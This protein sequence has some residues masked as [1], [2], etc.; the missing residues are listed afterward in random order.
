MT[1]FRSL[2]EPVIPAPDDLTVPQFIFDV[3]AH[4]TRPARREE[5]PCF[6]EEESGRPVYISE[7][8]SR[9]NALAKGIRACWGIG[10]GDVVALFAPNHVDYTVIAWAVHRLGVL[11]QQ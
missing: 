2:I 1:L 11:L 4:P 9:T 8:R 6:I 7:L 3:N 10:K 5:T